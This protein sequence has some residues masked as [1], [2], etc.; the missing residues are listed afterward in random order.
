MPDLTQQP[1]PVVDYMHKKDLPAVVR[2]EEAN[3]AWQGW[4]EKT[5]ISSLREKNVIGITAKIIDTVVGFVVYR[6]GEKEIEI[7]KFET[8]REFENSRV[9]HLLLT[10][11]K[12]KGHKYKKNVRVIFPEDR[13]SI[14]K[15][16]FFAKNA[17]KTRLKRNFFTEKNEIPQDGYEFLWNF[18][19][20]ETFGTDFEA[21]QPV[22][23]QKRI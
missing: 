23:K 12:D 19:E 20:N 4:G 21:L 15:Y 5:F 17:F 3:H 1:M 6:V 10:K 8:A 14:P 11:M 9:K 7:L 2:I 13:E 22:P 16:E 18:T